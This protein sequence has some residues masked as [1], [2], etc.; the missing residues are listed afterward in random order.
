MNQ[1]LPIGIHY[2]AT[3]DI[4]SNEIKHILQN[5]PTAERLKARLDSVK[6]VYS[7]AGEL[8]PSLH[9]PYGEDY[10]GSIHLSMP[11]EGKQSKGMKNIILNSHT[12]FPYL[13]HTYLWARERLNTRSW[14]HAGK[15]G[16]TVY[17]ESYTPVLQGEL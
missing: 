11:R 17:D 13:F 10:Y 9:R 7:T 16:F 2:D 1:Y 5:Y 15:D 14:I 3:Y 6:P 8:L 4:I 12:E